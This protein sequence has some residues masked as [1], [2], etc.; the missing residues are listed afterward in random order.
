MPN[1]VA[2]EKVGI[3]REERGSNWGYKYEAVDE[4]ASFGNKTMLEREAGSAF[5]S[6]FGRQE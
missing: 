6:N 3:A 4:E 2:R 1:L 5:C